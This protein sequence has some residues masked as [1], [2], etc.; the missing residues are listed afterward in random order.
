M[1]EIYVACHVFIYIFILF[2]CTYNLQ[3]EIY[4]YKFLL[5]LN[6]STNNNNAW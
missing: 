1:F 6:N 5:S 3:A 2:N 4:K